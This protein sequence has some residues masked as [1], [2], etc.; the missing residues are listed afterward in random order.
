MENMILPF[1]NREEEQIVKDKEEIATKKA[2]FEKQENLLLSMSSFLENKDKQIQ[3]L[4]RKIKWIQLNGDLP[5][6]YGNFQSYQNNS[7]LDD[8]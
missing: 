8:R 2:E 1:P 7:E 6:P 4:K 3:E 5:K